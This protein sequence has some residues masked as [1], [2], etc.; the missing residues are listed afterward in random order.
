VSRRLQRSRTRRLLIEIESKGIM[1]T[2]VQLFPLI[3]VGVVFY[4]LLIR[5]QRARQQKQRQLLS[6]L[7]RHDRI[8]TIG[9][10]HGTI[11]SV[12]D[13]TIRVEI[14]PGTIVTLAKGAIARRLVD[15]GTGDF[16]SSSMGE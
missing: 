7:N 6:S 10:F 14:A 3:L 12:N 16:G 2:L 15:A 4:F 8:V 9:G 5:P 11:D 1:D 13:D